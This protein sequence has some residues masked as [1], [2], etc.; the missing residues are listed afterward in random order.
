[1]RRHLSHS[2]FRAGRFRARAGFTILELVTVLVVGGVLTSLA[3]AKVTQIMVSQRLKASMIA[4][5]NDIEGAFMIAQRNRRPVRISWD[6]S[7][8]QLN[9]T[10]RAGT[11]TYRRTTLGSAYGLKASNVTFSVSPLEI[12]PNGLAASSLVIALSANGFVDTVF[13]SRA[14]LVRTK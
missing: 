5:Q 2:R 10:D 3:M 11:T 7:K 12:F 1:V 4:V 6:A 13:V 14:G 9:V 8:L